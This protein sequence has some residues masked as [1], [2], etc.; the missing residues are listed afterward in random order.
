MQYITYKL[1]RLIKPILVSI[2][3]VATRRHLIH[4]SLDVYEY[5]RC[6]I[7]DIAKCYQ[8][9]SQKV[10]PTSFNHTPSTLASSSQVRFLDDVDTS[11]SSQKQSSCHISAT[12]YR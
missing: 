6:Y 3:F 5:N 11:C 12:K 8:K 7:C 4:V 2:G 9:C 1:K 10:S